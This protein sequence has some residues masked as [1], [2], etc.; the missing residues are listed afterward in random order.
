LLGLEGGWNYTDSPLVDGDKLVVTPG[1]PEATMLALN[2]KT[3]EV[4]WKGVVPGGDKAG[5]SSIVVSVIGG[6]KQY[7]QLMANGLVG[8]SA[9]QGEM[10]WRYGSKN[11]RFGGNTAN[12]PTPIVKG[13]QVFASAGYGRGGALI[14]L[15]SSGGKFDVKEEYWN[16]ALNN[17][18]GG[19]VM[20][21]DY[22]YGD[23]DSNGQPW[24]AEFKTGTVKWKRDK[25]SKGGG[26][27]SMTYADGKL[28]IRYSNGWV[29]LVDPTTSYQEIS[30]FKVPNGTND[31]WAHPVVVGGK[32]LIRE[33][34]IVWCYDVK[35]K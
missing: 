1:G 35:E 32:M 19:I 26:S 21:G 18:H 31:C 11:D 17:K 8:F 34:D 13:D 6:T 3:G 27:A 16:K 30:T 24:C 28:Y 20:V 2:K 25:N 7:V 14:T 29:S 15:S 23:T 9:D 22:L 12:I 5:Y 4:I 33:K 10:L